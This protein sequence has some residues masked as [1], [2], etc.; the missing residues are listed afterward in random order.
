MSTIIAGRACGACYLV[1]ENERPGHAISSVLV[2]E[3]GLSDSERQSSDL[4]QTQRRGFLVTVQVIDVEPVLQVLYDSLCG[5]CRVFDD[6][7]IAF[8]NTCALLHPH[9]H[10]VNVLRGM[11][12]V[13]RTGNH[14]AATDV[15]VV[16][17]SQGH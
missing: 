8:L 2:D 4:V 11:R 9:N 7:A 3:H 5:A 12:V 10:C 17:Q 15:E 14:V 1:N 16:C 13:V 6:V